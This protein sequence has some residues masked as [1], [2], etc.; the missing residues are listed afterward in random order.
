MMAGAACSALGGSF[1]Y[2]F[3]PGLPF[4]VG[5]AVLAGMTIF[6]VGLIRRSDQPAPAGTA[7]AGA[8]V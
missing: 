2:R 3:A 1:L 4:I 7:P 6:A 5:G 8:A